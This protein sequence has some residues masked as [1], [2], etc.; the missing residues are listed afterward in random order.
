MIQNIEDEKK[1]M[2]R[3]RND[4]FSGGMTEEALMELIRQVEAEEMLHAPK[5]LKGNIFDELW[6]ERRAAKKRQVFTYRAKVLIAMAAALAVLIFMPDDRAESV[7]KVSVQQQE[8]EESLEQIAQRRQQDRDDDWERY[9]AAR[10]RG[11]VKGFFD[12]INEAVTQFGTDLYNN[13]NQQ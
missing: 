1:K 11:G 4:D 3:R 12:G 8:E 13:I 9:L 6:R 10:E 2:N 7:Q 5:Q